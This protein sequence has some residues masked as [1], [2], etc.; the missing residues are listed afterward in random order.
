MRKYWKKKFFY[1][2]FNQMFQRELRQIQE[3][4]HPMPEGIVNVSDFSELPI[5]VRNWLTNSGVVGK[6]VI[7]IAEIKQKA[8]M[9]L[10]PGQKKW[11]SAEAIQYTT[12]NSPAFIWQVDVKMNSFIRFKGRDK[13][14]NGKG[15]MLIKVNSLFKVVDERGEKLDEGSLQRYLGE[16]VWLPS[17][18]LSPYI[19]WEA[20]NPTTAKATM[21]YKGITGSGIFHFNEK[22]EF[23]KFSAHRY[24]GNDKDSK[25]HE[26]I[27]TVSEHKVFEGIKVPARMQATWKLENGDWTWLNL[28]ITDIKYN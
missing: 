5:S 26:W 13:F 8:T 10:K 28:E 25:R 23:I 1:N 16:M 21:N 14:M 7:R 15:E 22:G 12:T 18:A 3:A 4:M 20:I 6:P 27:I 2:S 9:Q 11:Y 24:M 19:T 17:L